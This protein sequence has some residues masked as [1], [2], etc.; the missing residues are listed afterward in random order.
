MIRILIADDHPFVRRGVKQVLTD[1]FPGV[2]IGGGRC[3]GIARAGGKTS[4]EFSRTGSD[5]AGQVIGKWI[6]N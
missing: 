4:M 3:L 2:A 6:F 5:D 1:E